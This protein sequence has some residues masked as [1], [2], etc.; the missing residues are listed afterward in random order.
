M[1]CQ[2]CEETGLKSKLYILDSSSTLMSITQYYD[3][4]GNFVIE[5]PNI[6]TTKYNCSNGHTFK[7][8]HSQD[9]DEIIKE[10]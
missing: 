1:I 7:V 6:I 5:D 4:N 2:M 8:K 9:S 3:E 10:V